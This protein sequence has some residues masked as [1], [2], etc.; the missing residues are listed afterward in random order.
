MSI[1][2]TLTFVLS[3][4]GSSNFT[5]DTNG[6]VRVSSSASLDFE[7]QA[8]FVLTVTVSD[9]GSPIQSDTALITIGV[10]NRNDAPTVASQAFSIAENSPA[11]TVVGT[12]VGSDQ[13]AGQTISYSL[14]GIG[15]TNFTIHPTTG[16]ITVAP[17]AVLDFE[18]TPTFNL[19]VTATDSNAPSA[20]SNA[21]ITINLLN[22]VDEL[23]PR[24]TSVRV[25]STAW[26]SSFRDYVDGEAFGG[27]NKGYLVSTSNQLMTL[28]WINLNQILVQ[29][30]EDCL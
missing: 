17:A 3:G 21:A 9:N 4:A 7:T 20:S 28:P 14:S 26:T 23:G 18:T 12:V 19:L 30:N 1:Q 6:I 16:V 15:A 2:A 25:N 10:Q 5:V 27:S 11:G 29:F 24:V 22:V 13:D 8:T